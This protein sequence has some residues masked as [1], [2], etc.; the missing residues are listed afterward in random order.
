MHHR[1]A[2]P[3]ASGQTVF[4]RGRQTDRPRLRFNLAVRSLPEPLSLVEPEP[5]V[6]SHCHRRSALATAPRIRCK[7]MVDM[8]MASS[9]F[10]FLGC[11]CVRAVGACACA[12]GE[13]GCT[14]KYRYPLNAPRKQPKVLPLLPARGTHPK[15]LPSQASAPV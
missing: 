12:W 5:E 11:W 7:E 14:C 10:L 6:R 1:L 3:Y 2:V 9:S 4:V 15:Y 8:W 13:K